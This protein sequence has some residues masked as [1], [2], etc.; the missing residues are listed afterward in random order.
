MKG[1]QL[2]LLKEQKEPMSHIQ[3]FTNDSLGFQE[4]STNV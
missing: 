4:A 1:R 3:N 2:V